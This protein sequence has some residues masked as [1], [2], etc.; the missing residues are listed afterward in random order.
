MGRTEEAGCSRARAVELSPADADARAL[1]DQLTASRAAAQAAAP[2]T[3]EAWL[4]LS[5]SQYAAHRYEACIRS[6]QHALELRPAYAEAYNN[7]CAAENA[8]GNYRSAADACERALAIQ[9]DYPLAR[10]NL[11]VAQSRSP[12]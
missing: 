12:R 7:I 8:L 5:L 3:P 2:A 4:T 10:N 9:P 11:A 1:L 6:S